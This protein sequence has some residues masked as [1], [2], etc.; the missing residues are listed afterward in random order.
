MRMG[1]DVPGTHAALAKRFLGA[2]KATAAEASVCS[3]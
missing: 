3:Y 2:S 1:A